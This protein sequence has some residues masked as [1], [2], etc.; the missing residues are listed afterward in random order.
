MTDLREKI[1]DVLYDSG[2]EYGG[3]CGVEKTTSVILSTLTPGTRFTVD[4]RDMVVVPV[5]AS[6]A[7]L[8]RIAP[9][10]RDFPSPG[11]NFKDDVTIEVHWRRARYSYAAMI[12][13]ASEPDAP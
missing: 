3:P 7:M 1:E 12:A 6:G 2:L 9:P 5:E 11:R 8:E 13:A 4:G 10:P